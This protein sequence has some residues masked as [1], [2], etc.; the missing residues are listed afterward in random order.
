MSVV[1]LRDELCSRSYFLVR[2]SFCELLRHCC[3]GDFLCI[4][5]KSFFKGDHSVD[6]SRSPVDFGVDSFQERI[7]KENII[8]IYFSHKEGMF[9]SVSF[10]A[11]L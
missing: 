9:A 8:A 5:L 10:A 1:L 6:L 4:S 11:D 3:S 7:A 2:R